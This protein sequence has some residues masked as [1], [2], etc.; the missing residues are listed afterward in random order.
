MTRARR[1]HSRTAI[2]RVC[3]PIQAS[4]HDVPW[5]AQ[6]RRGDGDGGPWGHTSAGDGE[7]KVGLLSEGGGA[8]EERDVL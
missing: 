2:A 1:A 8:A 7:G 5:G 4:E 3:H 6:G